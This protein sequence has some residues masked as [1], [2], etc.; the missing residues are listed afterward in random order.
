MPVCPAGLKDFS[1]GGWYPGLQYIVYRKCQSWSK[2]K[3]FRRGSA[4][5]G[6]DQEGLKDENSVSSSLGPL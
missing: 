3:Y 6:S 5:N 1:G 4:S 2:T